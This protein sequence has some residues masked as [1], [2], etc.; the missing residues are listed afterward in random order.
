NVKVTSDEETLSRVDR[1]E[2]VVTDVP[3]L[4]QNYTGTATLQAVDAQGQILP[5]VFSQEVTSIQAT[6]TKNKE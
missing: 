5:V 4:S 3:D 1:V 2:A 6:I